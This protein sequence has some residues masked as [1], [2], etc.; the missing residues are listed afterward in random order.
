MAVTAGYQQKWT[1]Q[2]CM[3]PSTNLV[4]GG[5]PGG[6]YIEGMKVC[7]TGVMKSFQN[8]RDVTT[9][10]HST[11]GVGLVRPCDDNGGA[12]VARSLYF[13]CGSIVM[14]NCHLLSCIAVWFL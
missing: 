6:D 3:T 10:L 14:E 11:L 5:I 8:Y 9:T 7:L 12:V 13:A 2:W 1:R 4:E